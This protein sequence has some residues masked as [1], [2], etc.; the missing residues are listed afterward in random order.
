[1]FFQVGELRRVQKTGTP[2][3]EEQVELRGLL[4]L[5][6]VVDRIL[7]RFAGDDRAVVG[8]QDGVMLLRLLAHRFGERAI[9]RPVVRNER[10]LANTH[11]VV[12]G[13]GRQAGE[14]PQARYGDAVRA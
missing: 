9:T 10:K 6:G 12:R 4:E 7:E 5:L 14:V 2:A 3:L 8:E 13:D 1:M 11:G